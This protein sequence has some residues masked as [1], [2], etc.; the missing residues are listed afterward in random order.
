[1]TFLK[2]F[3]QGFGSFLG[4]SQVADILLLDRVDPAAVFHVNEV[5]DSELTSFGESVLFL[6]LSIVVVELGGQSGELIVIH[7]HGEAL[8]GVLS[9]IGFYH[10]EGL[11]GTRSSHNPCSSEGIDDVDPAMS[12][13]PL[14]VESH[15][16]IYG[17]GVADAFCR[18]LETL[19]L[20]VE[21]VFEH[22]ASEVFGNVVQGYMYQN[23]SYYGE[24]HI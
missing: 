5:D 8:F 7:H 13:L 16:D 21:P 2:R 15:R 14:V 18:L 22:A 3:Y 12:E 23:R 10:R 17:V 6:V 20:Q 19:V 4:G 11:T 24:Q 9:D 1:M